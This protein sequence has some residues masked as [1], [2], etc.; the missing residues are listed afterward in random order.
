MQLLHFTNLQLNG[1]AGPMAVTNQDAVEVAAFYGDVN[2]TGL[3]FASNNAVATLASVAALN[4]NTLQQTLPGFSQFP[5]LD[6]VI[7]GEVNLS[8]TSNI[9]ISDI[10]KMNQELTSPQSTIPW[11][12]AGLT[13]SIV[14]PS[15]VQ[16]PMLAVPTQPTLD[17]GLFSWR[18]RHRMLGELG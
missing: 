18:R 11:I 6:P 4:A 1:I 13:V 14:I 10:N 12:P 2:N 16:G 8:P 5:I 7:I 9:T 15:S 3:P 17:I